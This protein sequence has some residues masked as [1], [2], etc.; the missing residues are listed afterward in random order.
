[1]GKI[2]QTTVT[3]R[4]RGDDLVP[5]QLTSLLGATQTSA[6]IKGELLQTVGGKE[7]VAKTGQW[8]LR[9]DPAEPGEEFDEQLIRLFNQLTSDLDTWRYISER[10]NG[11]LFVGFF[12]GSSNEGV[13][14][15]SETLSAISARGLELG[16]DIYSHSDE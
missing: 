1:M 10:Y 11:N 3:L 7:R 15:S 14:I 9:I 5:E 16:L 12:L 13:E 6:A 2:H 4:F 8:H